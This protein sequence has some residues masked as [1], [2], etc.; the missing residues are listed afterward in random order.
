MDGIDGIVG[1]C[2]FVIFMMAS[3]TIDKIYIPVAASILAFYFLI[4]IHQNYLWEILEVL[5]LGAM[6]F[7]VLLKSQSLLGFCFFTNLYTF[8][9]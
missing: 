6:F 3:I 5:F 2:Y 1:G 9:A 8:D 4:G 7:T